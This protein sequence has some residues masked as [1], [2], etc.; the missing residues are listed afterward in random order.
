MLCHDRPKRIVS[1]KKTHIQ[2]RQLFCWA[3]DSAS[4]TAGLNRTRHSLREQVQTYA[5]VDRIHIHLL[6]QVR[7]RLDVD[8]SH[9]PQFSP[10]VVSFSCK[11][12]KSRSFKPAIGILD[13]DSHHQLVRLSRKTNK[14]QLDGQSHFHF[15]SSALHF[16]GCIFDWRDRFQSVQ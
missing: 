3:N 13:I 2:Y 8:F 10:F 6:M 5:Q 14:T 9:Q 7:F 12:V 1:L 15:A 11:T 16:R 4:P